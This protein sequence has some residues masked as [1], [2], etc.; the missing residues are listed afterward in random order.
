MLLAL[1]Q[2][3]LEPSLQLGPLGG[4]EGLYQGK[5]CLEMTPINTKTSRIM[6]AYL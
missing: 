6:D 1:F 3:R 2:L 4:S 5:D